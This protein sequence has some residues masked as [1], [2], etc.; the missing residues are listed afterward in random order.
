MLASS[1]GAIG[2]LPLHVES[3]FWYSSVRM[4]SCPSPRL[5]E[6]SRIKL[7][8]LLGRYR[9]GDAA[10]QDCAE[11]VK[12]LVASEADCALRSCMPGHL[13]GSAW[14][15]NGGGDKALLLHHAKLRRWIQP[16]GHADGD[17]DL[18]RVAQRE[19]SEESGLASI[20]AV[21]A[22][23]FDLDI[24]QIPARGE[25]PE[26][27]HFDLRFLFR[28]DESEPLRANEESFGLRWVPLQEL[29]QLSDELS[30]HRMRDKWLALAAA[31]ITS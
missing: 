16:G 24:H 8:K 22:E 20:K 3:S 28:A 14:V 5:L 11:R 30:V 15:V 17:F 13:T 9:G 18:M 6:G 23:I 25:V 27:L 21:N 29:A 12:A 1:G 31:A 19:A 4:E 10:D 2:K 26:H 7:L